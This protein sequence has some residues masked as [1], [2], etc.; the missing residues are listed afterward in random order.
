MAS[1]YI[2]KE[3]LDTI[4]QIRELTS[5]DRFANTMKTTA[6]RLYAYQSGKII[7]RINMLQELAKCLKINFEWLSGESDV[8]L[9]YEYD[10]MGLPE[11][12]NIV[13]ES[14]YIFHS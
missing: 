5:L 9:D 1:K 11:T 6:T 3:R 2:F 7:P 13:D 10:P 14:T 8:L 12:D 4:M